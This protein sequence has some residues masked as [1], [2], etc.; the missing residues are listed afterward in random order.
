MRVCVFDTNYYRVSTG[1]YSA[2]LFG[3]LKWTHTFCTIEWIDF[4][5][6]QVMQKFCKSVKVHRPK[7]Q[8]AGRERKTRIIISVESFQ[9]DCINFIWLKR[10]LLLWRV[11]L[12]RVECIIFL[13]QH[14][15][16]LV[17]LWFSLPVFRLYFVSFALESCK[18]HKDLPTIP[19]VHAT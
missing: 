11:E 6:L 17:L 1:A 10:V 9:N 3:K 12:S 2:S 14:L 16:S 13:V 4:K 15:K 19:P 7:T 18:M 5:S 8:E